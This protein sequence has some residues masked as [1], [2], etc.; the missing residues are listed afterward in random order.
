[1]STDSSGP[2]LLKEATCPGCG[3]LGDKRRD[4]Y[5]YHCRNLSCDVRTFRPRETVGKMPTLEDLENEAH[6]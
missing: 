5:D 4:E 6:E 3:K 2:A 1:M